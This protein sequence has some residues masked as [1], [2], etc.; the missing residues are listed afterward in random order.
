LSILVT[1]CAGFIGAH[2][3]RRL[4]AD[5]E[6]VLG[7]D[8]FNA[9]Y[10]PELKAARV[11]WLHEAGEMPVHRVG[12]ED[13]QALRQLF[14][15]ERPKVV[16]HFAAQAGVRYSIEDPA[17]YVRSNLVGFAN[18]L[19]CCRET[20]V[21]HLV[22]ASTSSVYGLSQDHPYRET[23]VADHPMSFYAA[24]KRA[25]EMMAHSYAHLYG[26]PCTGLRFFTVYGP[27]GRPD[28]ALF[29]FTRAILA[30][31]PIDI[32]NNG[33]LRRD[34]TYVDD[35]VEGVSRIIR[36]PAAPDPDWRADAPTLG[37]STAPA[38]I[39]NI[40]ANQPVELLRFIE[41]LEDS[42]NL[43]ATRNLLPMQ[44]GD[45]QAT[46]ADVAALE[47]AVGYRPRVSVEEGVPRFVAWFRD[48]YGL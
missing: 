9:Y 42:L 18:L 26:L 32:Y 8:D 41:V 6:S 2:L 14:E 27:W 12:V 17:S 40:G 5:G 29:K 47:E 34:W 23:G 7:L 15:T 39:F 45:V 33:Q 46:W 44:P 37:R 35:I 30:G 25:D 20:E 28:M 1:G 21:E 48:Y 43:K 36:Q 22:Y 4:V 10:D 19:E 3:A 24:T 11:R 16:V 13:A 38:R 31:E